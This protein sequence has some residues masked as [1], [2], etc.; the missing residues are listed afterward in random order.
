MKELVYD[1]LEKI[2][3]SKVPDKT[4]QL[5]HINCRQAFLE[6][7]VDLLERKILKPTAS[8]VKFLTDNWEHILYTKYSMLN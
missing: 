5:L 2:I 1:M 7:S 3:E 4:H 8:N 6:A